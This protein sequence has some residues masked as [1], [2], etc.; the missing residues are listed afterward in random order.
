MIIDAHAQFGPGLATDSPLQPPTPSRTAEDVIA[1]L[2]RVGIEQAVVHAPRWMGGSAGHDF[3]DPNYE[4]AN[5]AINA[6]IKKYPKRLIGVARVNPKFGSQ[7]M[8][9]L[10]KCFKQYGF[11]GLYLE[12]ASE[13]ISYVDLGLLGPLLEICEGARVPVLLYTWNA[14]SQPFQLLTLAQAF[15]KVNFVLIHPGAGRL[16]DGLL[17]ADRTNNIYF[18][19]AFGHAGVARLTKARY[20]D[21]IVF[22][23]NFPFGI[24]EVE[25]Q[26]VRRWGQ[27][28]PRQLDEVLG[29]TIARLLGAAA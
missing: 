23:T 5:A 18:D 20:P 11:R 26:R 14:P 8:R 1:A 4:A 17:A 28:D 13:G 29:G 9:E 27:L 22:S 2:D 15:P 7:A 21:R 25:L 6:G 3:I 16:A 12:N 19:T 24:P 10:E